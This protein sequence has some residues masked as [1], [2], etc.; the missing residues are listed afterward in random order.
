MAF[1]FNTEYP[2]TE[3]ILSQ[4]GLEKIVSSVYC[5]LKITNEEDISLS[6]GE[7]INLEYPDETNFISFEN[8][9]KEIVDSWVE[10]TE[11]FQLMKNKIQQQMND[12]LNPVTTI[13][14]FPFMEIQNEQIVPEGE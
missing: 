2:R 14:S 4:N 3:V 13:M 7:N 10:N 1:T 12:L 9:T 11:Q 5:I 6:I 8:I